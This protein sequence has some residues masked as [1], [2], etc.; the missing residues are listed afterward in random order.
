MKLSEF[1]K[2]A[3]TSSHKLKFTLDNRE[4]KLIDD[5]GFPDGKLFIV[6]REYGP[7]YIVCARTESDA[8]EAWVDSIPPIPLE[9]VH[10]AYN[11]FDKLV[12][13]LES[14][15]HENNY[16]TRCFASRWA[17]TFFQIDT[18]NANYTGAWDRWE[19]DEAYHYQSNA[20]DSGIVN[21]GHYAWIRNADEFDIEV[22]CE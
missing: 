3:N 10:E 4:L 22:S 20:T 16:A 18:R 9:E 11:A 8:F 7:E 19:I 5:Y 1:H 6:G 14:K 12:E 2:L 21:L 15:G 13:Y 17:K